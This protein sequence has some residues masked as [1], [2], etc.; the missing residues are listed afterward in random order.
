MSST[1]AS[2]AMPRQSAFHEV[3]IEL[4]DLQELFRPSDPDPL[5]GRFHAES[6][7]DRVLNVARTRAS[8]PLRIT[9]VLP[10]ASN[11]ADL[12]S[13]TRVALARYCDVRLDQIDNDAISLRHEGYATLWRGLLFLALCM[14]GSRMVG[15]PRFLPGILA[16]FLDE[17]FII[18]GWVALWYPLDTLLYQRWPLSRERRLY[19]NLR[20]AELAFAFSG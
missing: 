11:A 9:L 16:R 18:A 4:H 15:E 20:S 7:V 10:A 14:L 2:A 3:R 8:L 19:Q 5:G 1:P 13:R 17:G 12:D 6:G